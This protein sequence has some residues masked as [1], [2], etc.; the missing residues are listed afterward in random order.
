MP[1]KEP[2]NYGAEYDAYHGTP[3]QVK[4]RSKRNQAVRKLDREGKS[5]RDGKEVDHV[6]GVTAGNGSK[7]L[8]VVKRITNRKKQ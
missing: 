8:R 3:A 4:N 2:R 6:R 1:R 7:N 5:K